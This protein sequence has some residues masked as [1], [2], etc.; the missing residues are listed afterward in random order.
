LPR[1]GKKKEG[2]TP[3][4][5]FGDGKEGREKEKNGFGTLAGGRGMEG[6]AL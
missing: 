2:V 6:W 5:N 3:T 1:V 4:W